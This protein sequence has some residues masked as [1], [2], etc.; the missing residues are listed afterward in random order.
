MFHRLWTRSRAIF[1]RRKAE[2]E[3]DEELRFHFDRLVERYLREGSPPEEARR[4]ASLEF[5]GMNQVKEECRDEHG[6]Q[7]LDSIRQDL[8]YCVRMLRKSPA[9]TAIA[10][11]TLALG[12]GANTTIFGVLE[13]VLLRSLPVH[14]PDELVVLTDP[15]EH[16]T[17]FGSQGGERGLLA[18][19]EFEYLRDHN[20]VFSG[21]FAADSDLPTSEIRV[22]D[23]AS[24]ES[25]KQQARVKLV[26]GGY[27]STL[28]LQPAAGRLFDSSVDRS[29]NGAP[30]AVVSYGFW[31]RR[32]G[33]SAAALQKSIEI[34]HNSFQIIGVAPQGFF[35][36]TVGQ[37]IDVWLPMVMQDAV[38]PGRDYLTPSPQGL[39]NEYEW[40]LVMGRLK[41]GV[42]LAQANAKINVQFRQCLEAAAGASP[43][44]ST[45][46][47]DQYLRLKPGGSGA[48]TL[49][50][51]FAE[52]LKFL[53]VLVGL[54]LLIA[55]ANVANLLLARGA[56]RQK[57][58]AMRLAIGAGRPRLIRQLLTE[59]LILSVLGAIAGVCLSFG[60]QSLLM[61]MVRGSAPTVHLDLQP[62]CRVLAFTAGVTVLTAILF[63]LIPAIRL[64]RVDL[65]PALK[66]SNQ[67][68]QSES[69]RIRFSVTKL[70]V[71][72]Q[73]AVSLILLVAAG[74]FVRSLVRLS[75]V[76]LGY[77]REN[78]LLFRVDS[79]GAGYRGAAKTQL[80]QELLANL[81]ALPGLRGATVSADGLFSGS[82]SGDP[83]AVKGYTPKPDEHMDSRM[84]H[85]GPKYFSTVGIPILMGREIDE[86]DN[87]G[88]IRAAVI[89]ESF[90]KHFFPNSNPIGR[91]VRDT[92]TGNPTDLTVV[93][94]V[95]D[96]KYNSLRE[97]D[98]PRLY[99]PLFNPMWEENA[100]VFEVRTL[101]DPGSVSKSIREAVQ[102]T[103]GTIPPIQ[104]DTMSGLIDDSLQ[105]DRFIEQLSEAFGVLAAVLAAIGLY[106]VMAYAVVRRTREIGVRLALGAGPALIR[107]QV[108]RETLA[109]VLI[110]I[111][112]GVPVALLGTRLVRSMVFGI[113]FTDPVAVGAAAVLLV[114]VAVV[115]GFV[116]ARR[117]SRVDPI[118]A[119]RY[120]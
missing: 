91:S 43:D 45:G 77:N 51:Q 12:I 26:S 116:P 120:E 58:F 57:E 98:I 17:H 27:F 21:I 61:R 73:V 59:S 111:V 70:L 38:Y 89:N 106:G 48:S 41:P 7:W 15:D 22:S 71:V 31:E 34:G 47:L 23:S 35:G 84:D 88:A 102:A 10:V 69:M 55:C 80:Y 60:A 67:Q 99:A 90:A 94:V 11:L 4:R 56:A 30:V 103:S 87:V 5:G 18:Y 96:A 68:I 105:T 85:I 32:F 97:K 115:A 2:N 64:T 9:F 81:A 82:E 95:A 112:F 40:L 36:D 114:G 63:G 52:P 108:L 75:H 117:A 39:V 44:T 92:Y 19:S 29:R 107:S 100:V 24:G 101:A 16:G 104:I 86:R 28:G 65:T 3:L 33:L 25:Q 109:L 76:N 78:L 119:L 66:A 74:L 46:K 1:G 72:A 53:M 13:S 8:R 62:D 50:G 54:V 83:V 93:G 37:S 79:S 14:H 113:E 6:T 42:S 118:V 20:D 110:G 49:R